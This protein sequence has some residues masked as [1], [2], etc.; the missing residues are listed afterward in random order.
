S[1]VTSLHH[2]TTAPAPHPALQQRRSFA[3][4]PAALTPRRVRIGTEL[5]LDHLVTR[6]GDVA[7]MVIR[8]QHLPLGARDLPGADDDAAVFVQPFLGPGP[9]EH[10]CPGVSRI[11][12]KVVD[13]RVSGLGPGDAT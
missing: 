7:D 9:A 12:E 4:W 6:E 2:P 8:Y 1:R 10:E 13:R 5:V 11:G 3:G